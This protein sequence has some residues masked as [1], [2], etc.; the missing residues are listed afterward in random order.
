[1][2]RSPVFFAAAAISESAERKRALNPPSV[3]FGARKVKSFPITS[4]EAKPSISSRLCENLI[5]FPSAS[6]L[7]VPSFAIFVLSAPALQKHIYYP[8]IPGAGTPA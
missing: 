7:R 2:H 1:M 4:S 6:R 3:P 8:H 5:I